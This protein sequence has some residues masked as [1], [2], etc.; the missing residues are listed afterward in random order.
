VLGSADGPSSLAASMST[1]VELLKGRID[2]GAANGVCWGSRSAL[3]A[4]VSH[5]LEL[6]TELEVLGPGHNVD[7]TENEAD[8]LW[9]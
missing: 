7:L 1:V 6:K 9:I 4:A 5:F 8:T 3:V 2:A